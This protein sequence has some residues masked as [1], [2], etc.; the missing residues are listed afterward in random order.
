M[1]IW[2]AGYRGYKALFGKEQAMKI[3]QNEMVS[4]LP[5]SESGVAT[6]S[7]CLEHRV[8]SLSC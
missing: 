4:G 1:F 7:T 8:S 2:V 3:L 6:L 5:L